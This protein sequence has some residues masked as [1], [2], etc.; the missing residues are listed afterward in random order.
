MH[1]IVRYSK[2][3]DIIILRET[4]KTPTNLL[5]AF[6]RAS[7]KINRSV[8]SI[9]QRYYKVLQKQQKNHIFYLI[10]P[11]RK[12]K[13]YKVTR[14]DTKYQPNKLS[15]KWKRILDILFEN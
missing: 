3:E 2:E 11:F 12:S 5:S 4:K 7:E 9:S 13:N 8:N 10:S 6:R 1:N 15:S 14:K